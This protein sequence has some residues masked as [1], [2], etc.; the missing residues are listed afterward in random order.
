ML[1]SICQNNFRWEMATSR[2]FQDPD[3]LGRADKDDWI[4]QFARIEW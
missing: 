2:L 1:T 3:L 4:L